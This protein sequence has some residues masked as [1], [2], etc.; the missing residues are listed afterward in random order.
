MT[1]EAGPEAGVWV[2][3][4]TAELGTRFIRAVVTDEQGRYL[5]PDLPYAEYDIWVPEGDRTRWLKVDG[6]GQKPIVVHFQ[7]RPE[8]LAK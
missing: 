4:E 7:V 1:S 2:V 6:N 5:V 3:A 8:P